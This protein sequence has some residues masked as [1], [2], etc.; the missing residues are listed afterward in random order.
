MPGAYA[1]T[2][3]DETV[4]GYPASFRAL[5]LLGLFVVGALAF[6]LLDVASD[7]R[8]TG[9]CAGCGD[10]PEAAAGA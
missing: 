9:G 6:I 5:A 3:L 10:K 7:G 2:M 8:L 4:T 1:V